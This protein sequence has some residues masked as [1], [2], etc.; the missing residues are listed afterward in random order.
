[1]PLPVAPVLDEDGEEILLMRFLS[2]E[3]MTFESVGR[4][5][6]LFVGS[7]VFW[8][9]KT[10][11]GQLILKDMALNGSAAAAASLEPPSVA[12]MRI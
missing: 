9:G 8:N 6:D 10:Q 5:L 12:G 7:V 4:D 11:K 2:V 3:E 1:M